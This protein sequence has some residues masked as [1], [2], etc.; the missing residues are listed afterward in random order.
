[1]SIRDW[2]IDRVEL[3]R[4]RL[5]AESIEYSWTPAQSDPEAIDLRFKETQTVVSTVADL[6]REFGI[7]FQMSEVSKHETI[8]SKP[9][10][11]V[12][13]ASSSDITK[14]SAPRT[15]E[16]AESVRLADQDQ[17]LNETSFSPHQIHPALLNKVP[18]SLQPTALRMAKWWL[19]TW[20]GLLAFIIVFQLV[21]SSAMSAGPFPSSAN[22]IGH[23]YRGLFVAEAWQSG[24]I[25]PLWNYGWYIGSS[26]FDSYPP[27]TAIGLAMIE[28]LGGENSA[29]SGFVFAVFSANAVFIAIAFRQQLTTAGSIVAAVFFST[30]PA[31]LNQLF[32]VGEISTLSFVATT[33]L[34]L[35]GVF[36]H[37]NTQSR[38]SIVLIAVGTALGVL[39]SPTMALVLGLGLVVGFTTNVFMRQTTSKT[40]VQIVGAMVVGV[41][42]TGIWVLPA[43]EEAFR[44]ESMIEFTPDSKLT[45][46]SAEFWLPS[47]RTDTAV[48]YLG[49]FSTLLA[50]GVFAVDRTRN[51]IILAGIFSTSLFFVVTEGLPIF[52]SIP[53]IQ[54]L[55]PS[56]R[57]LAITGISIALYAGMFVKQATHTNLKM[58]NRARFGLGLAAIVLFVQIVDTGP[59]RAEARSLDTE[60]HRR[61]TSALDDEAPPGRFADFFGLP[62]LS[63]IPSQ[64]DREALYG[65]DVEATPLRSA[66]NDLKEAVQRQHYGAVSK[67]LDQWWVSGVYVRSDDQ[68]AAS[69]LRASGFEEITPF[70]NSNL[71]I[72]KRSEPLESISFANQKAIAVGNG[73]RTVE[74]VLPET[75]KS[76]GQLERFSAIELGEYPVIHFYE[77]QIATIGPDYERFLVWRRLG[78]IPVI[79]LGNN[80]DEWRNDISVTRVTF[81]TTVDIVETSSLATLG[82]S[83]LEYTGLPWDA[84][85]VADSSTETILEFAGPDGFSYPLLSKITDRLG[86][87]YLVGGNPL[88]HASE[89]GGSDLLRIV[90]NTLESEIPV[91]GVA[92][93]AP[94]IDVKSFERDSRGFNIELDTGTSEG[95]VLLPLAYT[96]QT[97]NVAVNGSR[98]EARNYEGVIGVNLEPGVNQISASFD[99]GITGIVGLIVSIIGLG[100]LITSLMK[101]NQSQELARR[102]AE[103][104]YI[105]VLGRN[106]PASQS[107]RLPEDD[108][109][110][111]HG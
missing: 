97:K 51:S 24:T 27:V 101:W 20:P 36:D 68:L 105:E 81:P 64:Y 40:V 104:P 75:T 6:L 80:D 55:T 37:L 107:A 7:S 5:D 44:L 42:S 41:L 76:D 12:A 39:T 70:V 82:S 15:F 26:L 71:E 32:S 78:G 66:I 48:P 69:A 3:F 54:Q 88:A 21:A 84:G 86:P 8:K 46:L 59:I 49:I 67:T 45:N 35:K 79:W 43:I 95:L 56:D 9:F 34:L 102:L 23:L 14:N 83:Q 19:L 85:V 100:L 4:E 18:V 60:L 28:S 65:W 62:Q 16:I 108:G 93:N 38:T 52:S 1:M 109:P 25:F 61:A 29:Y 87:I 98:V 73:Q 57:Y 63:L 31:L 94:P 30:S 99:R 103:Y 110:S 91:L 17:E 92:A 74:F 90:S 111:R 96:E 50:I 58:C 2:S 47:A 11:S 72:W 77:D 53:L 106:L 13:S 10:D 22:G 89:N 33:P